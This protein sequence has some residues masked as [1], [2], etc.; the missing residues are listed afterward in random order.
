[1]CPTVMSKTY[2]WINPLM[3]KVPNVARMGECNPPHGL[4]R[5]SWKN[6]CAGRLYR[7][8]KSAGVRAANG[9]SIGSRALPPTDPHPRRRGG[10][11]RQGGSDHLRAMLDGEGDPAPIDVESGD[12]QRRADHGP[13]ASHGESDEALAPA[14]A[15]L[16]VELPQHD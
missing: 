15:G 13:G 11:E 3:A 5:S 4:K 12:E 2:S 1:M 7:L 6:C 8:Q 14:R 9:L 10:G 16:G